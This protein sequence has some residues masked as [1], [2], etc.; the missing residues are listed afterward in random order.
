MTSL[1]EEIIT[2]YPLLSPPTLTTPASNRVCNALALLQCVASHPETR[3][4]FLNAQIPLFLYPFLNTNSKQRS[5]EYLRLTS[6]GVIGAL[7]KNDTPEVIQ[8]LLTT[9]IIPLCLK[10]MEASS[11]LSKTVAI[12]IVQKILVDDAGLA[13]ICQTFD[14]FDAVSNVLKLMIEQLVSNPT[15]RLLRH[16]IRCYLRMADNPDARIA[17]KDRLPQNLKDDTFSEILRE[18]VTTRSCLAQ[19]LSLIQQ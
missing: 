1:L 10:I 15:V 8:F 13:Y 4:P 16:V 11:E 6:L 5:F 7:V 14:R 18:D 3:T 19:L 17:L 9:E 2:V 12:F